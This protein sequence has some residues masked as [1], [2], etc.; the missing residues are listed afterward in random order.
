MRIQAWYSFQHGLWQM[1]C[2]VSQFQKKKMQIRS[3]RTPSDVKIKK[4]RWNLYITH[5]YSR[6]ML[7]ELYNGI[8]L[9]WLGKSHTEYFE[10]DLQ[11]VSDKYIFQTRTTLSSMVRYSFTL[12]FS[13]VSGAEFLRLRTHANELWLLTRHNQQETTLPCFPSRLCTW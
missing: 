12:V 6:V 4:E 2:A 13:E 5:I 7:I 8:L 11:P 10:Q 3:F 9:P 1:E